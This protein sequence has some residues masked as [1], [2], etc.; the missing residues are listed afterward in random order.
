MFEVLGVAGI[1]I[2]VC[3]Y[4]PQVVHLW[5]EHCS[6]G[7]STRAWAMWL[8]SGVLIGL[9]AMHR[10]D[11]L[12][13]LLQ[14]SSLTSAAVILLLARRYRGMACGT[15]AHLGPPRPSQVGHTTKGAAL[16]VHRHATSATI[17]EEK[18]GKPWVNS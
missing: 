16:T 10:K 8:T 6:A 17:L 1:A 5:R 18:G 15:H 4:V 9:L 2:S 14:I 11:P 13:I 7:V 3:A 12:F